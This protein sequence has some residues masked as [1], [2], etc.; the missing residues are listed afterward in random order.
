MPERLDVIVH[1]AQSEHYR[2]FPDR[3]LDM[4]RVNCT[5]TQRLLD[6]AARTGVSTVVYLSTGGIYGTGPEPF[7]E[8]DE[9]RPSGPLQ[10]YFTTKYTAELLMADY[11]KLVLPI[12]F[13]PFFIYGA[14][15]DGKMLIPR[16]VSRIASGETVTLHGETGIRINPLH[17]SDMVAAINRA[18]EH[19]RPIVANVAGPEVWALRDIAIAIGKEVGREPVFTTVPADSPPHLVGD[20]SL[21]S[22]E[23]GAPKVRFAHVVGDLCRDVAKHGTTMT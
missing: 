4:F 7:K 20:I 21:M 9:F 5:G 17:V 8:T 18:L 11:A 6:L 10:H 15:Q 19:P 2:D 16:L 13:R 23:L 22:R 14:G 1:L 12:I 3:A